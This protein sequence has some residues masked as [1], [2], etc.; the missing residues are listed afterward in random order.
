MNHL[1]PWMVHRHHRDCSALNAGVM[2]ALRRALWFGIMVAAILGC[3]TRT[4]VYDQ[5]ARFTAIDH[6]VT[7]KMRSSRIPGLSLA[8]VEGDSIVFLGGYGSADPSG[9]PVT[10][11]T[12]FLIGS[13]TK[14][15]T[16]LATLQLA[17]VGAIDLDAPVRQYIPWFATADRHESMGITVRQLLTMTSGLPQLYEN[18]LWTADDAGALERSVRL[19][20]HAE[21]AHPAGES[22]SRSP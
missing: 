20:E 14:A 4:A 18:Q 11:Q 22:L 1:V 16:T 12:P 7:T 9:R 3:D 17:E 19:L 5:E 21:L 8:I 6:Y 10:P 15:F 13:I 2:H